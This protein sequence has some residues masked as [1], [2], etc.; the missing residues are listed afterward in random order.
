MNYVLRYSR[1]KILKIIWCFARLF[2]PLHY[3]IRDSRIANWKYKAM[4]QNGMK[5]QDVV[6]LMKKITPQGQT[7]LNKDIATSLGI[8]ASEVSEAMERSRVAQLVD[9]TKTRINTLALK[10]FL[11]SGLRYVFPI[12]PGA[13][14]RGVPTAVSAAPISQYVT[15]GNEMFVWPYKKGTMRG[16]AITPLYS[17]IPEAVKKDEDLYKLL[18]IADTLRMGRVRER[19]VA[20][21]ELDKYIAAYGNQ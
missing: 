20:I 9:S 4:K 3:V 13:L 18:V 14:V 11:I 15:S 5:P 17:T 8:S 2:V 19:D 12:Q 6:V 16:Q 7:M 10:D 21:Q 1:S